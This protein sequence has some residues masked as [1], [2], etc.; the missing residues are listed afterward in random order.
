M[1]TLL[2]RT[3]P[4][5]EADSDKGEQQPRRRIS[6]A[7][8][9]TNLASAPLEY[10]YSNSGSM[11][12]PTAMDRNTTGVSSYYGGGNGLPQSQSTAAYLGSS[13]GARNGSMSN[14]Q[15]SVAARQPYPAMNSYNFG[16]MNE[17]MLD[18]YAQ[19]PQYLLPSQ[20]PRASVSAYGVQDVNR[21]WTPMASSS[22][23]QVSTSGYENDPSLRYG[24]SN[25][26]YLNS[27]AIA[28][29]GPEDSLFPGSSSRTL[30]TPKTNATFNKSGESVSSG[31]P[32][33]LSHKSSR[34]WSP[35]TLM[36]GATH[37]S[38]SSTSPSTYSEPIRAVSTSPLAECSKG[39]TTFG[40]VSVSNS[41]LRKAVPALRPAELPTTTLG[42]T[43]FPS[44]PLLS[45]RSSLPF[46]TPSSYPPTFYGWNGGAAGSSITAEN[47]SSGT[48]L[49]SGKT[50][51]PIRQAPVK[52][53][54]PESLPTEKPPAVL[55]AQK[56]NTL[57]TQTQHQ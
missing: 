40:Y 15:Y 34:A 49:V 43:N 8:N 51:H 38:V 26:P 7:V 18:Q 56:S 28:G 6:L 57:T 53:I 12:L 9:S 52:Q 48:T 20:D 11:T 1:A 19:S 17:E 32:S 3:S 24:A 13:Y 41:P 23:H 35:Q 21:Q 27:S 54:P 50:Y 16:N 37:G 4:S 45:G 29:I 42:Y 14:Q 55:P 39:T 30:P 33:G 5:Q 36:H 46:R 25:F 31:L 10:P 44:A 2:S 47:S 22:R